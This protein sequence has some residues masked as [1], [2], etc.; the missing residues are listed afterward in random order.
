MV[1][2]TTSPFT[3]AHCA[4]HL[5]LAALCRKLWCSKKQSSFLYDKGGGVI[6]VPWWTPCFLH[7][8]PAAT[9]WL[10]NQNRTR[11][12]RAWWL[13]SPLQIHP[14]RQT[15]FHSFL[16]WD[17]G[18]GDNEQM[19]QASSSGSSK[20]GFFKQ[21]MNWVFLTEAREAFQTR[22]PPTQIKEEENKYFFLD[23]LRLQHEEIREH[24]LDS[25]DPL[26]C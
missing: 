22:L 7:R 3:G 12:C 18:V 26:D 4:S 9:D 14:F 2:V 10:H 11:L 6:W 5:G 25:W 17:S 19:N 1:S 20:R 16:Q 8:A 13:C 23:V 15:P 24:D 21:Q